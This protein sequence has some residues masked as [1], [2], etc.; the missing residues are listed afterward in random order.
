MDEEIILENPNPQ[1]QDKE[2]KE[3]VQDP[4][5]VILN[6]DETQTAADD[7]TSAGNSETIVMTEDGEMPISLAMY[8]EQIKTNFFLSLILTVTVVF[9]VIN[10]FWSFCRKLFTVDIS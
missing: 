9:F 8:R 3:Q 7:S 1:V 5:K 10:K 6:D 4:F 2:V